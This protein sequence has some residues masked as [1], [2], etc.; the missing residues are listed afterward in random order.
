MTA[1]LRRNS[2]DFWAVAWLAASCVASGC[3]AQGTPAAAPGYYNL[4]PGVGG[5]G[6]SSYALDGGKSDG[7]LLTDAPAGLS[8]AATAD[9]GGNA[10][11]GSD[12]AGADAKGADAK[13]PKDVAPLSTVDKDGDGFSPATGDCDETRT[14]V[15]PK[16]AELCND[17]D[18]DCNGKIDDV[19]G[20]KDGY[21]K[22]PGAGQDCDDDDPEIFPGAKSF[23]A[24]GKDGDCDGIPDLEVDLDSDGFPTCKDCN[25]KDPTIYPGAPVNCT[26]KKDH[27][28][29]G[30]V[31]NSLDA[32]GDGESAC[33]DCDDK[34]PIVHKYA[35]ELCNGKDED[36]NGVTDDMDNDGD[37]YS[38]CKLPDSKLDC[39][40]ND[41]TIN[42][43]AGRN[44][45]NG[46]DNDCSGKIDAQEDGDGDGYPGCQDCNDYNKSLNPA[47]LEIGGDN[48]D[49][50]CNGQTDEF[51]P[52]CDVAGMSES[53]P[54]N[55]AKSIELCAGV[56]SASFPT[57]GA[58]NAKAIKTSYGP[59]NKPVK[60]ASFVVLSSGIA[61]AKGQ[62]GY[63]LP[64]SGSSFTNTVPYPAVS[65]KNS[66]SVYDYTEFK[67]ELQVPGNAKAF[68]FDFNF[69]SS[70][71]PEWVGSQFNDKF[72][73]I[74][75]S[76]SFKGNVSF[77]SK[78]N[79]I[80]INNALFKVCTG[81]ALGDSG[82]QGTGYEN[83]VGGGT[84]WLTTTSPVTPGETIT[85]KFVIFD[86]GDHILDSAVLIDNFRWL[87][88]STGGGPSTV[89]PGG[90]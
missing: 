18:D 38:G 44:C 39:N 12:L 47:A 13:P 52:P 81:C 51:T 46:K 17:V 72:L 71:Y 54:M 1:S 6:S 40:D 42:P 19:D 50:N 41:L 49:N 26:D 7:S 62:P 31:D 5:D 24:A 83:G 25:D 86:E 3:A 87:S 68:A 82:L 20:D 15:N 16:S 2:W 33:S 69:M 48:L 63:V 58:N 37:G 73:A 57:V 89:R 90:G 74:L 88:S 79:C 4:P 36:C 77:D 28:C 53:S 80:S 64:Q 66:G 32:D 14:D 27:N 78:G 60:G 76:Q 65:C 67:L 55:F 75:T 56:K 11:S 8:D 84:G 23:C 45:K 22:C 70:E 21:S 43:G 59:P 29:D 34:D 85:L 9:Q 35:L 61:A 30:V 10:D